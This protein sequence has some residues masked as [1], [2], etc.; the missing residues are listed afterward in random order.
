M[1]GGRTATGSQIG[2][3]RWRNA[4]VV[5]HQEQQPTPEPGVMVVVGFLPGELGGRHRLDRAKQIRR[6]LDQAV[7]G[8]A[9]RRFLITLIIAGSLLFCSSLLRK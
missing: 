4:V 5:R 6:Q 1:Y 7:F 8:G 9:I 2:P 3:V